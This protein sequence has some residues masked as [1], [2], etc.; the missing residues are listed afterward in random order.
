MIYPLFIKS[1]GFSILSI[2]KYTWHLYNNY[3]K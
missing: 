1:K 3:D 2:D